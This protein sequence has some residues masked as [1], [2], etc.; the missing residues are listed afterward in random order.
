MVEVLKSA[1]R[2]QALAS[3]PVEDFPQ[4]DAARPVLGAAVSGPFRTGAA[5]WRSGLGILLNRSGWRNGLLLAMVLLSS[6]SPV[7]ATVEIGGAK[8]TPAPTFTLPTRN[9]KVSLDSLRGRV[10][11]VD[12]WASWCEPCRHSFTWMNEMQDRFSEKGLTIVAIN[13]DKNRIWA[14]SFLDKYPPSFLVAFDPTGKTA[15][16]YKV[17][18]VPSSFLISPAGMIIEVHPGFDPRK[19]EELESLIKEVCSR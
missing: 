4:P 2:A 15:E 9:G 12:F 11:L 6:L 17:G 3:N 19:T 14:D 13:L 18:A 1:G 8:S 7:A 10:V 5:R 16:A